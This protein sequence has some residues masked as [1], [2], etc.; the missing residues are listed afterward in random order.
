[1]LWPVIL[2]AIFMLTFRRTGSRAPGIIAGGC[3][4][5]APRP[6]AVEIS[7]YERCLGFDPGN[8]ELLTDLGRA[9][10]ARGQADQGEAAYRRALTIDPH[11]SELH[12]LLGE[13]LLD[14]GDRAGARREAEEAL[15]WRPNGRSAALL[16]V[17]VSGELPRSGH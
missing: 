6:A 8:A 16:A 3:D 7:D 10:A 13:L 15:R 11:N 1:M 5:L 12:V 14:R 4:L 17:R 2:L 9:Y